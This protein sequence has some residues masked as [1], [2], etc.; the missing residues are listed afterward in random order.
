M[1]ATLSNRLLIARTS[2][3]DLDF[4][5]TSEQLNSAAARRAGGDAPSPAHRK[6]E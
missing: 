5:D 3:L 6:E 4:T 2:L 1:A